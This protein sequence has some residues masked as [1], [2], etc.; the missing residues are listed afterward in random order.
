MPAKKK[1]Q[2]T[3]LSM[4]IQ[5]KKPELQRQ[6]HNNKKMEELVQIAHPLW[7]AL[8]ADEREK[9]NDQAK[10]AKR[11]L[12]ETGGLRTG[13]RLDN[14]GNLMSETIN[15]DE[16][17]KKQ[18]QMQRAVRETWPKGNAVCLE[19]FY[20]V[21]FEV[22]CKLPEKKGYLPA[23]VAI[24][25]YSLSAGIIRTF[26]RF[27]DPGPIPMG[28]RFLCLSTSDNTHQIPIENFERAV[29][30]YRAIWTDMCNFINPDKKKLPVLYT[31]R[32]NYDKVDF[33]IDWLAYHA[34]TVNKLEDKIYELELVVADLYGHVDEVT[35]SLSCVNNMFTTSSF[36][37]EPS[38]R[39]DFHEELENRHCALAV[40]KIHCFVMSD[41]LA[42]VYDIELTGN[43]VPERSDPSYSTY[44]NPGHKPPPIKQPV[45]RKQNRYDESSAISSG[46]FAS[47]DVRYKQEQHEEQP[48]R[49]PKG[50]GIA[51]NIGAVGQHPTS[52]RSPSQTSFK[53]H[54]DVDTSSEPDFEAMPDLDIAEHWRPG[55]K[56]P[57]ANFNISNSNADE[58]PA[59]GGS[60][61]KYHQQ[62]AKPKKYSNGLMAPP[63]SAVPQPASSWQAT[64]RGRGLVTVAG[65]DPNTTARQ[66]GQLSVNNR[67]SSEE[68]TKQIQEMFRGTGRGRGILAYH[69]T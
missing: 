64:G 43:H 59:L 12:R 32:E 1:K 42:T 17:L 61:G 53:S 25:E 7:K 52:L 18:R 45:S 19:I 11:K 5:D 38:T 3:G 44:V 15:L 50:R 16:T 35:P 65:T 21:T 60:S 55:P 13:G 63:P 23:E 2:I 40:A 54:S 39:C 6:G 34:G 30:D 36:D 24:V 57:Q 67:N 37:Y 58:W 33:C 47:R 46:P 51:G 20:I 48:L 62:G 8:S 41:A 27:I 29:T 69:N 31:L 14:V 56:A 22:L 66:F 49:L 4:F 9:Y 68:K 26:H 10:E 28:F